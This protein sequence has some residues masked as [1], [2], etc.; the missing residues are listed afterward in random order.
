MEYDIS[1]FVKDF[2][3]RTLKNLKAIENI[4]AEGDKEDSPQV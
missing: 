2:G 4:Y 1:A 3:E